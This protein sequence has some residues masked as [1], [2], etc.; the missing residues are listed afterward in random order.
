[1]TDDEYLAIKDRASDRFMKLPYVHAVGIGSREKRGRL[2]ARIRYVAGTTVPENWIPF[3]PVQVSAAT[4][5]IRLQR[6]R[7][8]RIIPGAPAPTVAPR[9]AI[10]RHGLDETPQQ[11]YFIEEEEVP[12]G[13]VKVVRAF[14]RT[15]WYDGRVYV[16]MGRRKTHG[17]GDGESGLRF[18]QVEPQ[19]VPHG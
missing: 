15:R 5:D 1:M 7:M 19:V 3:L 12:S 11:P 18:D 10:L 14:Q 16:W 4:G 13:G 6:G 2:C 9:G 8:A 17:R